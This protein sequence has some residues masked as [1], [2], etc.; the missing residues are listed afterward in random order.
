MTETNEPSPVSRRRVIAGV[1]IGT[2]AAVGL[3]A[4]PAMAA[5]PGTVRLGRTNQHPDDA[6]TRVVGGFRGAL[7]SVDNT[8]D[9]GTAL[10]TTGRRYGVHAVAG[11]AVRADGATTGIAATGASAA[12]AA[13]S[14]KGDAVRART[15]SGYAVDARADTG[16]AVRAVAAATDGHALQVVGHATFTGRTTFSSAGTITVKAGND[17]AALPYFGNR[18]SSFALATPRAYVPGVAVAAAVIDVYADTLTI[19]LSQPTPV[20]LPVAYLILD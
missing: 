14:D 1:T 4:S 20:D 7:L 15:G 11:T 2:V 6:G 16:T 3:D 12:V 17:R 8:S 13:S 9:A 10:H 18:Q 5:P 19:H